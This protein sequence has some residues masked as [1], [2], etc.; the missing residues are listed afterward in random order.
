[1]LTGLLYLMRMDFDSVYS[2]VLVLI[3]RIYQTRKQSFITIPITVDFVKNTRLC[4]ILYFPFSSCCLELWWTLFVPR[5]WY[6]AT[7]LTLTVSSISKIT[8]E[9]S[10]LI[11]PRCFGTF[12]FSV[13]L[14]EV[15]WLTFIEVIWSEWE[16][17]EQHEELSVSDIHSSST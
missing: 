16:N 3:E 6:S 1:M 10:T 4:I 14:V 8:I 12:R 5:V 9:T 15:G 7:S 11:W 13:T 17:M 2:L